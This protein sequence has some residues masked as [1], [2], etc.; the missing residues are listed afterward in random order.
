MAATRRTKLFIALGVFGL[1]F[2]IFAYN[3]VR[4]WWNRGY[5]NGE[6]T[7]VIRKV[8]TKGPPYCKYLEGEMV[9]TGNAANLQSELWQF[10]VD[11]DSERNPLVLQLKEAE[12][13]GTKVTLKYRQDKGSMYRCTPS[14]YFVTS[15]EK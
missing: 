6:R 5:S 15:V 1:L 2:L 9:L 7:G 8:A 12:K 4:Y 11:D 3:G 14:E 10:S 13:N